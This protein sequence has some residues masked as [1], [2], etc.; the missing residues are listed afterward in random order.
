MTRIKEVEPNSGEMPNYKSPLNRLVHSLRDAYDNARGKIKKLRQEIKY[1]QIKT[2]DLEKSRKN[3]KEETTCLKLKIDQ[4]E[5]E[6]L[7]VELE[8]QDLKKNRSIIS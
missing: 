3:Y 7:M 8:N 5:K 4:I 2:R 1:Y 6:K